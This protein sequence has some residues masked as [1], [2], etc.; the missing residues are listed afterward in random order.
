VI[1][2]YVVLFLFCL[3]AFQASAQNIITVSGGTVSGFGTYSG[4]AQMSWTQTG[5]YTG[6]TIQATLES[7][8]GFGTG[9]A[10]LTLNGTAV[11]NQVAANSTLSVNGGTN[12][13]DA[14]VT[15]FTGLTLGPGTYYL[16]I[17]GANTNECGVLWQNVTGTP[18]VTTASGVTAGPAELVDGSAAAYP[19]A[20][21][22]GTVPGE[23]FPFSVTGTPAGS[24]SA[25]PAP[26]AAILL[27]AGLFL[28][29]WYA[30]RSGRGYR[31]A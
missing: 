27:C 13:A 3:G 11:G 10:Y 29:F 30:R 21:A 8:L 22:F 31:S 4:P 9:T 23:S 12:G 18:T 17:N 15:L 1:R 14:V 28:L 16:T 25:T 2:R 6:V 20:S 5:T 26:P 24:P 7:C 19:P